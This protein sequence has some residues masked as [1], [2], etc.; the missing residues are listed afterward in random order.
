M[1]LYRARALSTRARRLTAPQG[2]EP[3]VRVQGRWFTSVKDDAMR[4]GHATFRSLD[5]WELIQ[6]EIPDAIVDSFRVATTPHTQC[7]L[8]PIDY[9]D[10]PDT[11]YVVPT[12]FASDFALVGALAPANDTGR[13]RDYIFVNEV[14]INLPANKRRE[15]AA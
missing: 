4:F 9:A 14:A 2:N 11:E 6:I 8:S 15:I 7:G 5:V 12:F 10:K 1:L 13:P 3:S